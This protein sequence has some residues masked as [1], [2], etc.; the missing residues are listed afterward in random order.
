MDTATKLEATGEVQRFI[1]PAVGAVVM[2][3]EVGRTGIVDVGI[4]L[5]GEL[6][7]EEAEGRTDIALHL[8]G[9]QVGAQDPQFPS[10]GEVQPRPFTSLDKPPDEGRAKGGTCV[11]FALAVGER[12]PAILLTEVGRESELHP[13]A[14]PLVQGERHSI[15]QGDELC[16]IVGQGVVRSRAI[17]FGTAMPH[18]RSPEEGRP[19]LAL[20]VGEESAALLVV[21]AR[22]RDT[23][24]R[25]EVGRV[26]AL[27]L[28]RCAKPFF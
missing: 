12:C 4:G 28:V 5:E 13:R 9:T 19:L 23:P 24:H 7:A 10:R 14:E 16:R 21:V 26:Q 20:L 3:G 8:E 27:K 2:C 25:D 6:L 18:R 17:G 22:Q 15:L 11:A 1:P